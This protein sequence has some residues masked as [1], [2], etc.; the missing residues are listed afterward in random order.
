MPE[1][2]IFQKLLLLL[3]LAYTNKPQLP[4]NDDGDHRV[5]HWNYE[6][7]G[8]D[9]GGTCRTG[10]RQSPI[11]LAV[12]KSLLAAMP[13]I[14]FGNY[15]TKLRPPLTLVNN[16][17]SAHMDIPETLDN[18]RPFITG[19]LLKGRYI[20]EGLHFHWG[21]PNWRGSEHSIQDHRYD[22]EMHIVHR[23]SR[24]T[25][26]PEALKYK[27]GVAVL[28]VMFKI[29]QTPDAFFPGLNKIFAQLPKIKKYKEEA[30]ILGSLTLGQV[31]GN[32]NTRDF[33]TYRGS[34]TTPD[35]EEAVTWTVFSQPLPISF[36][37]VSRFWNLRSSDG[38]RLVNNYRN[39]QPRN[40]RPV[41]YRTS[42]NQI[43]NLLG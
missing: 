12:Q 24:Y 6:Y 33:F 37:A 3:P 35:C 11:R 23:N 34:L 28:G 25:D 17:H 7:N 19:G 41:Y 27:D 4:H 30:T 13:R 18:S 32:L 43:N 15:D 14:T 22:V 40:N 8:N 38:Y 5:H 16:G 36:A 42:P 9:W 29:V 39:I 26:F 20:A 1:S 31:F 10:L 2:R 21:S